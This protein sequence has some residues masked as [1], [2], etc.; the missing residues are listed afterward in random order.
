MSAAWYARLLA[1][2]ALKLVPVGSGRVNLINLIMVWMSQHLGLSHNLSQYRWMVWK[3]PNN[4]FIVISAL[5]SFHSQEWSISNFPCSLTKNILSQDDVSVKSSYN[6]CNCRS[7][8][9]SHERYCLLVA[10]V[11]SLHNT[12]VYSNELLNVLSCLWISNVQ[13]LFV[14]GRGCNW[15][16]VK[17]SFYWWT[18]K[19]WLASQPL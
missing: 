6:F 3:S 16:Q 9:F 5:L 8:S 11:N 2:H 10:F 12:A 14:A 1:K 4:I 7:R 13:F 17:R 15:A 19:T 18:K